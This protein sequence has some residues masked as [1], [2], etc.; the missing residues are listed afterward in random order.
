MA[1][2]RQNIAKFPDTP[3]VYQFLVLRS[4]GEGGKR[5]KKI[6]YIGKA[7]SLRD[8][9]RSYF[10]KDIVETRS[11]L[12]SKMLTQFDD[13]EVIKTDSV[14]EA[15]VLEAHLI[16]KYQPEANIKEKD[17]RSFNFVIITKEDFP[18]VLIARGRELLN[19]EL[20]RGTLWKDT[21]K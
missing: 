17:N 2:I 4:L 12:V 20:H 11:P 14:L 1:K 19:N 8:R 13:I 7:T 10:N 18:R 9:V 5:E 16:K 21:K 3:G 15:L 6:L